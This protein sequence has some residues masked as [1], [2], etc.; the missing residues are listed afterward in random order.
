MS[1]ERE[2]GG[3][4]ALYPGLGQG[5]AVFLSLMG[6]Y[7]E[8]SRRRRGGAAFGSPFCE[9]IS[10]LLFRDFSVAG[11]PEEFRGREQ[12]QGRERIVNVSDAPQ[13]TLKRPY[14]RLVSPLDV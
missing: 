7:F 4:L 1:L 8:S 5:P 12:A 3:T 13:R 6:C 2:I 11:H 14:D 10:D 9:E